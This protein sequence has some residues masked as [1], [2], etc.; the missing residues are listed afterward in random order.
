M[1]K[2]EDRTRKDRKCLKHFRNGFTRVTTRS[3]LHEPLGAG[4]DSAGEGKGRKE[5]LPAG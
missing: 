1:L 5:G 2:S 3:S 4:D